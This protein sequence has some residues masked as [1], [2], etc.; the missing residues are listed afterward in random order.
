M[1][2]IASKHVFVLAGML[3]VSGSTSPAQLSL[4]KV[5][6]TSTDSRLTRLERFFGERNC[7]VR[8]LA[9]EFLI[10]ADKNDLDWRLLPSISLIESGGGKA[11]RNN[12]VFGWAACNQRFASIE[13]GIH[14]VASRIATSKLYR[15]KSVDAILATYNPRPDYPSR[16][17]A[18]MRQIGPAEAGSTAA[19]N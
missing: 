9:S 2:T 18:V 14:E 15:N 5:R 8:S 6:D 3:A 4:E 19:L 16:V 12:N 7:P 17:K 13:A 11:Y 1:R 10:A